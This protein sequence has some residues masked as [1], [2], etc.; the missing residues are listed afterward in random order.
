MS[1]EIVA[2]DERLVETLLTLRARLDEQQAKLE[3]GWK[4]LDALPHRRS[5]L[6]LVLGL[7]SRLVEAQRDWL[8]DVERELGSRSGPET[9]G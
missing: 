3:E 5:Y 2:D 4:R 8:D 6:S 9:D 7:G 1:G